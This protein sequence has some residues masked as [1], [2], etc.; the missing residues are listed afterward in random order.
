MDAIARCLDKMER[1]LEEGKKGILSNRISIDRDEFMDSITELRLNLPDDIRKAHRIMLD[2]E[3]LMEDVQ[4]KAD[5][6]IEDAE[7]DAKKRVLSHEIYKQAEE[8]A[9]DIREEAKA[10]FKEM[11]LGAIEHVDKLLEDAEKT[12]RETM[13]NLEKQHKIIMDY[14]HSTMDVL[15]ENREELRN[16]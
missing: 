8:E 3:R 9:A 15:Y 10:E 6:I 14:Y 11:R 7:E 12:L 4:R 1:L 13:D 5:Q 2:Q 16:R